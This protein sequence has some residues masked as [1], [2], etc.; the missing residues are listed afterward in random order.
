MENNA[1]ADW[2]AYTATLF[3]GL[4]GMLIG[5]I[6]MLAVIVALIWP[7]YARWKYNRE[8]RI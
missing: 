2:I 5:F 8:R 1:V 7:V 6:I 3:G 4:G